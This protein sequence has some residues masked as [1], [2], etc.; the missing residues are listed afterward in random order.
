MASREK[1]ATRLAQIRCKTQ[2]AKKHPSCWNCKKDVSDPIICQKCNVIQP[3]AS[4]QD[5]F[6]YMGVKFDFRLNQEDLKQRFRQLQSK[7]HPDKFMMATPEEKKL[8]EEHSRRLN[9]AYKELADPFR[10]AKYVMKEEYGESETATEKQQSAEYLMEMLERNEEIDGMSTE[11]ELKEERQRIELEID[12]Q[13]EQLAVFFEAKRIPEAR[14]VIGRLTYLYSLKNTCNMEEEHEKLE[15]PVQTRRKI[16]ICHVNDH[17]FASKSD[18]DYLESEARI[19]VNR[20]NS[21]AQNWQFNSNLCP[22]LDELVA[23]LAEFGFADVFKMET[24]GDGNTRKTRVEFAEI[25]LSDSSEFRTKRLVVRD[26]WKR[27]FFIA[28]GTRFGGHFL[29]Y[30]S[31][32]NECHAEFV[33]L[34]APIAENARIAAMRCCNQVKKTLLLAST[35]SGSLRPHY[36]KCTCSQMCTIIEIIFAF[37]FPPISVLLSNGCSWH[38]LISVLLTCLFYI[39]GIIHA[40]FL[41][42]RHKK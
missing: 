32:P 5:F 36:T 7:L 31:S 22:I 35:S 9:E 37:L 23:V 26:F 19:C 27:G 14:D 21:D 12:T 16:D 6:N 3:V 41:I 38:I 4:G 1:F 24:G 25:P 11:K 17:F 29:V 39:P 30:T 28:D 34:C 2:D 10:R 42:C 8:S 15:I 33:L 20:T 18:A 40:L 13:L